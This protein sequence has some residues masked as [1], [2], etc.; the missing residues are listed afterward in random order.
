MSYSF[1]C[2]LLVIATLFLFFPLPAFAQTGGGGS[3]G[4]FAIG[5]TVPNLHSRKAPANLA[6]P[7]SCSSRTDRYGF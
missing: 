3:G 2:K 5:T 6:T 4:E 1:S 7:Q